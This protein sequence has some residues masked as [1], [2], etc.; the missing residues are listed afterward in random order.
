LPALS[1][2]SDSGKASITITPSTGLM[3]PEPRAA[4]KKG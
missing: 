4:G 1:G 3:A 2:C